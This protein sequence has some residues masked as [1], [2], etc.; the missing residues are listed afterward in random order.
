MTYR[1]IV[2]LAAAVGLV[3]LAGPGWGQGIANKT[4][5]RWLTVTGQ[6]AGTTLKARDQAEAKAL[7]KAVEQGCGVFIKAQSKTKNFRGIYD[8]VFADAVGYVKEHSIVKA[9]IA[10]GV[11]NVTVRALVSTQRFERDWSAIAHTYH[12][13][14]NPRVIIAIAETTYTMVNDLEEQ[15]TRASVR[16]VDVAATSDRQ[17]S[18]VE[19]GTAVAQQSNTAVSGR[20]RRRGTQ[21]RPRRWA[22]MTQAQRADWLRAAEARERSAARV[23]GSDTRA[24]SDSYKI[25]RRVASSLKE[26]GQVQTSIEDFFISR[27][28][29]LVDRGTATQVNKRDIMLAAAKDDTAQVAAL[30]AR[31]KADV[32]IIGSAAAKYAREIQLGNATMYRYTAKLVVRAIRTDSAQLLASKTFTATAN[33]TSKTGGEDKALA[34][35]AAQA[36]PK[37]L[38]AVVEA[39]RKQVNVTRDIRLQ[40]SGMTYRDWKKFRTQAG[41][42]RGVKAL[43]MRE[44]TE[45]VANIDVDYE[46]STDNLAESLENLKD[47]QLEVVEFN[48]NR[49]KL[50]MIK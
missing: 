20:F 25:W 40:I 10:D 41:E 28:I 48:P 13:E 19:G 45:S 5:D 36:S 26:G 6:A 16:A 27:D 15:E 22:T 35:L 7:R 30:G 2:L 37:L 4:R 46:F 32:V 18:A 17:A 47:I 3:C 31:F 14:N 33:S 12:Q 34:K 1:R 39:W 38:A 24:T 43:R 8:K 23:T 9:W 44:I 49:L 11:Y 21:A 42:L 50:K 29:K